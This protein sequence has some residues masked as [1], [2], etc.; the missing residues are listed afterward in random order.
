MLST[1]SSSR[2]SLGRARVSGHR[3][4]PQA[5]PALLAGLA[6]TETTDCEPEGPVLGVLCAPTGG[7]SLLRSVLTCFLVTSSESLR[8]RALVPRFH[9]DVSL[10][11]FVSL[12]LSNECPPGPF[13]ASLHPRYLPPTCTQRDMMGPVKAALAG[14]CR[15]EG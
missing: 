8:W 1:R 5:T 13:T 4:E 9:G 2:Y 10:D 6:D 7:P 11:P 12:L 3:G 15:L 14:G